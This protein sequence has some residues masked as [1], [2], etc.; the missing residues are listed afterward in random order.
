MQM[1]RC[2]V[3]SLFMQLR[4]QILYLNWIWNRTD[5]LFFLF[6]GPTLMPDYKL[7]EK[8]SYNPSLIVTQL[9]SIKRHFPPAH[10]LT[11]KRCLQPPCHF[12]P[13]CINS[14]W[15]GKMGKRAFTRITSHALGLDWFTVLTHAI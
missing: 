5:T 3:N 15:N 13:R 6:L 14:N 12:F 7:L 8:L 10:P 9:L 2:Y 4:C 1:W 11:N